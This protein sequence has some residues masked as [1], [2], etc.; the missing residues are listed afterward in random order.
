MPAQPVPWPLTA[1]P[2]LPCTCWTSMSPGNLSQHQPVLS[3][4]NLR[5]RGRDILSPYR[6]DPLGQWAVGFLAPTSFRGFRLEPPRAPPAS[7]PLCWRGPAPGAPCLLTPPETLQDRTHS[8]ASST[9]PGPGSRGAQGHRLGRGQLYCKGDSHVG[10][11]L[12][13]LSINRSYQVY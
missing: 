6:E 9:H 4:P 11:K 8:L 7:I 2:S 10:Y 13:L 3:K 1:L 12:G 5:R